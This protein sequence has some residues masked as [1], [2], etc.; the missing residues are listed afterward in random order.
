MPS[1][2]PWPAL[3]VLAAFTAGAAVVAAATNIAADG[4]PWV[5]FALQGLGFLIAGT[6]FPSR[7][8]WLVAGLIFLPAVVVGVFG[9]EMKENDEG[10]PIE[11]WALLAAPA[12]AIL[13]GAGYAIGRE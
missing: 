6:I 2:S 4:S 7:Y 9:V 1:Q 13:F 3:A 11:L 5:A 8:V 10:A 12:F